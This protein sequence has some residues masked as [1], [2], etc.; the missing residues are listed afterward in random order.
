MILS[1]VRFEVWPP[2]LSM[3]DVG[4]VRIPDRGSLVSERGFDDTAPDPT[5]QFSLER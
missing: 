5:E 3:A 2:S 4:Y 1:G